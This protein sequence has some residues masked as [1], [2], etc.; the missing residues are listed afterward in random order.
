MAKDFRRSATVLQVSDVKKS[1]AF[2]RETLGFDT[3]NF[4]G[5]P[6]CFCIVG[7][8][9]VTLFLDQSEKPDAT[10]PVNQYWASY[11][12]VDDVEA[13]YAEV[14]SKGGEPIEPPKDMPHGCREFDVRDPDGH[15]ICF[16]QDLRPGPDGPGL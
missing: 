10:I 1:E 12:Y 9:T 13:Y 15:I 8:G 4:W 6:P 7:R 16:G 3:G 14:L 2:Y 5:E 11:I